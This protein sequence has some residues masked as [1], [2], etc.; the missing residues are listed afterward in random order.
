MAA[1]T[2][3]L[4]RTSTCSWGCA[5]ISSTIRAPATIRS[6]SISSRSGNH[7]PAQISERRVG[8]AGRLYGVDLDGDGDIDD[9]N[10]TN[11]FI[12]R[13]AN[14]FAPRIGFAWDITGGGASCCGGLRRSTTLRG[15]FGLTYERLFYA[16]SPFF[17]NRFDFGIPSLVAGTPDPTGVII[18]PIPL[19]NQARRFRAISARSCLA[20]HCPFWRAALT[21]TS[22]PRGS[23]SGLWRSTAKSPGTRSRRYN[24]R[25]RTGTISSRSPTSTGQVRRRPSWASAA[26]RIGST[27]GSAP[28]FLN[29]NGRSNYN[30][31]IAEVTNSAWR[32]IGL[33]FTARYRF[34]KALDNVNPLFGNNF[35]VFGGS[36]SPNL[37][38]PFDPEN[39]YGPS[40]FDVRHRFIGSF[41]WEVPF[42]EPGCCGGNGGWRSWLRGGWSV[43]G[44]FQAM[45]GFPFDV[46]D[47]AAR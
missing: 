2:G 31:F 23:L 30:A 34:A 18:P 1:S 4:L 25:A 19:I 16:V 38:S 9:D 17:Q 42:K 26:R 20:H 35:G 41:I 7:H 15:S 29:S 6:S 28:S 32:T 11:R 24:M 27:R 33:Q 13:D 39:D 43:T 10:D 37:L 5:T 47:C 8:A 14:N 44:I 46:F 21:M 40:N 12:N 3:A 45:T 22:M 36:F